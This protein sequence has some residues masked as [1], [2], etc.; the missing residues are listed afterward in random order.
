MF[1]KGDKVIAKRRTDFVFIVERR[2][3]D[4]TFFEVSPAKGG[5]TRFFQ[6]SDLVLKEK[7]TVDG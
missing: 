5:P 2:V 4:T 6:E 7:A 1:G 3:G